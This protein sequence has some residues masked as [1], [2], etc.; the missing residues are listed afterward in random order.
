[1]AWTVT[2]RLDEFLAAAGDQLR[3]DPVL[4]T[5]PLTVLES[6]RQR[7]QAAFGDDPPVYGW[8]ASADGHIDGAFLQTPPYPILIAG[9]PA[10][11]APDLIARLGSEVG[12]PAAVNLSGTDETDF[13]AAWAIATGGSTAAVLRSRLHRLDRLVPPDPIPSGGARVAGAA[14]RELLIEWH[15]AFGEEAGTGP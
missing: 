3:A 7:G 6:L 8:H 9:L 5:V 11:S 2:R 12:L 15:V 10:G 4:H 14:D 1:M 13:T